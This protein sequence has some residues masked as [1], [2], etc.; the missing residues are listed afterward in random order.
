[1][2]NGI[3]VKGSNN[4]PGVPA[5]KLNAMTERGFL[6]GAMRYIPISK[7]TE[8]DLKIVEGDFF[9]ARGNGSLALVG[10]G[11][12]AQEPPFEVV[13]PDTMIRLRFTPSVS[14]TE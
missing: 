8:K 6:Y 13:F 7:A 1:M 11:T 3:S 9:V 12:R 14:S 10:R 4:P 2:C 5:L